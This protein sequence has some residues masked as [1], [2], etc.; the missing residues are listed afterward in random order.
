M[1]QECGRVRASRPETTSRLAHRP[2][3]ESDRRSCS[4]STSRLPCSRYSVLC[5]LP[6]SP[7][8]EKPL[9]VPR[10]Q[11]DSQGSSSCP[12]GGGKYERTAG[13]DGGAQRNS[14][15]TAATAPDVVRCV[16]RTHQAA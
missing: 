5:F 6:R 15:A 10:A 16:T 14:R 7:A 1:L 13:L 11:V 12:D 4:D 3:V 8:S 2:T 9:D